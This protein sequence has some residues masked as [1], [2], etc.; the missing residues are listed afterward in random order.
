MLNN[1]NEFM[2]KLKNQNM[3]ETFFIVYPGQADKDVGIFIRREIVRRKGKYANYFYPESLR[4]TIKIEKSLIGVTRYYYNCI[5]QHNYGE[6]KLL[7]NT[8]IAPC[9]FNFLFANVG[10]DRLNNKFDILSKKTMVL[11]TVDYDD[12]CLRKN[13]DSIVKTRYVVYIDQFM[14]GHSDFEK[15]GIRHPI[16]NINSF[17][18]T[19]NRFFNEIE[20]RYNCE[21]V[22]ALHPKAEYVGNPFEG[23]KMIRYNTDILIRDSLFCIMECSTAMDYVLFYKKNFLR[24]TSK[25]VLENDFLKIFI[26]AYKKFGD[27]LIN[28]SNDYPEDFEKYMNYYY[29]ERYKEYIRNYMVPE[30]NINKPIMEIILKLVNRL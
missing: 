30:N 12:Y 23:R 7:L 4:Y 27:R 8:I 1:R 18:E 20:K 24:I 26:V 2:N 14:V 22:I 11:H 3:K 19:Y 5:R 16:S 13:N 9:T 6:L 25:E 21:V 17:F 15:D 28:I 10:V 29:E